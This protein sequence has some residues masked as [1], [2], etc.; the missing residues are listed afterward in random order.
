MEVALIVFYSGL[1]L[2][3]P[4]FAGLVRGHLPIEISARGAKFAE[5]TSQSAA[6]NKQRI[7]ELERAAEANAELLATVHLEVQR[8]REPNQRDTTQPGVDSGR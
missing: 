8:L 1:L 4:A 6:L 5:E 7:E 3:T 2:I